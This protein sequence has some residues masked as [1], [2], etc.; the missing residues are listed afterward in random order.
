MFVTNEATAALKDEM[1]HPRSHRDWGGQISEE[2]IKTCREMLLDWPR[3]KTQA[4]WREMAKTAGEE[5]E[6]QFPGRGCSH[7]ASRKGAP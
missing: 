1:S 7:D 2:E 4:A 5:P 6:V 3:R